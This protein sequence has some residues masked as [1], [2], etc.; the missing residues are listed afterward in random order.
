VKS[1]LLRS[2]KKLVADQCPPVLEGIFKPLI[3]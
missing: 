3:D 2:A 1:R